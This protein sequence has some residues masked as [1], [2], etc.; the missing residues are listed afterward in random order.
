MGEQKDASI[1][2]VVAHPDDETLGAGGTIRAHT[3]QSKPVDVLCMTGSDMRNKELQAAG[4]KLGVRY[5]YL[6]ERDDFAIGNSLIHEVVGAILKSQPKILITHSTSDYN[7]NHSNCAQIVFEAVEW[8]SHSTIFENAHRVE[9]IYNM[10]INTLLSRPNV[11]VNV[12][13]QYKIALSALR[14]HKSQTGKSDD[15][16]LK[17][18]DARTRLRG[19]QSECERAEAFSITLPEHAGPFYPE[20]HVTSL[21]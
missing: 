2:V 3:E 17:L 15:Y 8:A 20:N 19:V 4:E 5:L 11:F 7:R 6:S 1:L 9:R 13:K 14:E 16:Y 18:Y 10:E 21:I 12:T